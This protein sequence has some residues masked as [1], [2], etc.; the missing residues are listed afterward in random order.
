MDDEREHKNGE[1]FTPKGRT[2]GVVGSGR[3]EG[4][5]V[6]EKDKQELKIVCLGLEHGIVAIIGRI[7]PG[8]G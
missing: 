1:R 7:L 4:K 6:G 5:R 8:H 3:W 2:K